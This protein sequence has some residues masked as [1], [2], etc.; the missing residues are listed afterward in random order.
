[1]R[2]VQPVELSEGIR[3]QLDTMLDQAG[4]AEL[5]LREALSIRYAA[6]TQGTNAH[7]DVEPV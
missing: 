7:P 1:V 2:E 4:R 5:N 6:G 3:D